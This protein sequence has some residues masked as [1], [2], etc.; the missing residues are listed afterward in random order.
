[1]DDQ[2]PQTAMVGILLI[3]QLY[4]LYFLMIRFLSENQMNQILLMIH[5]GNDWL[6]TSLMTVTYKDSH[7]NF[8]LYL[9]AIFI[10]KM[11]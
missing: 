4:R 6:F 10:A 1:M 11:H 9:F 3:D 5:T 8:N 7:S 2:Y